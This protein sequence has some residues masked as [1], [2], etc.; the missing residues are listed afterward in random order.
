MTLLDRAF[1]KQQRQFPLLKN[2]FQKMLKLLLRLF[3][4][5]KPYFDP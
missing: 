5:T 4:T 1:L 3:Q 2:I